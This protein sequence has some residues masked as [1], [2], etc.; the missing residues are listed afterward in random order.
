MTHELSGRLTCSV[1][2][3][4]KALGIGRDAAYAAVERGE[5]PVLRLG[6]TI[7]VPVPKLLAL[8]G[9]P[10]A[11]PDV[12]HRAAEPR[13]DKTIHLGSLFGSVRCVYSAG[14]DED[15]HRGRLHPDLDDVWIQ[16]RAS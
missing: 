11:P 12:Q 1:P 14:H 13:C 16:W 10:D 5:I 9:V 15:E 7:R 6:R 4:A 2:E 3:A 8:L